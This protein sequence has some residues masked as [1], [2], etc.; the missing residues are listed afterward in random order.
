MAGNEKLRRHGPLRGSLRGPLPGEG[1]VTALPGGM[2]DA[3]QLQAQTY[4]A[5]RRAEGRS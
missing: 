2:P 1:G 4:P 3:G 5:C